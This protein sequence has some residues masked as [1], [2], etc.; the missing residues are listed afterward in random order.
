MRITVSHN[1]QKEHVI[2]RIDAAWN[3]AMKALPLAAVDVSNI[4]RTW[5][6][7]IMKFSLDAQAGFLK[8]RVHGTVEVTDT[9][10]ILDADLGFLEK[11]FPVETVRSAVQHKIDRLLT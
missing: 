3:D 7:S 2:R 4:Q 11:L 1:K 9:S 5:N 10:V 6:G 8:N